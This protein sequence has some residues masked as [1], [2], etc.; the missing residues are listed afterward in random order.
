M[1]RILPQRQRSLIGPWCFVDHYGPEDVAATGG[2]DVAPHPHTGL[3]TVSWL[4]EGAI[5]HIDSGGNIGLVL[6]GEVNLMTA[7]A[8]ICHSE[9]STEQTTVLHGVQL[10]LALPES[11]RH[12]PGRRF[13]HHV[14]EVV[15]VGDAELLVFLGTLA[16]TTSPVTTHSPRPRRR[17]APHPRRHDRPAC[18]GILRARGSGRFR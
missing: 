14:P 9:V 10:W 8:G 1:H 17:T 11:S 16:G 15:T 18:R 2:M 12:V 4:F 6:P 3:Q 7:S 5:Q 13:E